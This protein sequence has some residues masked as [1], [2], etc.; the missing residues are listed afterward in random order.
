MRCRNQDEI[1]A[2]V[3]AVAARQREKE[4]FAGEGTLSDKERA[5]SDLF[6]DLAYADKRGV[7]SLVRKL[8]E[9]QRSK[10]HGALER[11]EKQVKL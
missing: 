8:C 3:T 6:G 7:V 11:I 5:V 10:L 1:L 4:F 9:V 2:K